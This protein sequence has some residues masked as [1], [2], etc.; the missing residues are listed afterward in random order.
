M[1]TTLPQNTSS[2][3]EARVPCTGGMQGAHKEQGHL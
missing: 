3:L 2:L 1:A